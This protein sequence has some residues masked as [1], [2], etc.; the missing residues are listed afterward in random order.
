MLQS[1][2]SNQLFGVNKM[3]GIS[4]IKIISIDETR[5]P[6]IRQEPYIDIFFKLS[7][8]APADWCRDFN[9]L[10]A[11]HESKP[12]IKEKEGLYIEAWV[13]TPDEIVTYFQQIKEAVATCTQAYIERIEL[14][15]RL[16][17]NANQTRS[18][19][20]GE[21]GRLNKIIASLDFE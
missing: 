18:E 12:N 2:L 11:E 21:Q 5:P 15:T 6:V 7:H 3:E 1:K 16:A 9:H 17:S 10:L 14:E 19:E 8:Q 4:D 20:T 13:R